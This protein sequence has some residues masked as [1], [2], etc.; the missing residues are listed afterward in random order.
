MATRRRTAQPSSLTALNNVTEQPPKGMRAQLQAPAADG[1]Q[2]AEDVPT[3]TAIVV[4][5]LVSQHDHP[6]G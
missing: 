1:G 3:S 5:T 6:I 2:N 4:D